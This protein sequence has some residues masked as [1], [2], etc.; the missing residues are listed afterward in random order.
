MGRLRDVFM[1]QH[2]VGTEFGADAAVDADE[3]LLRFVIP[4]HGAEGTG[5]FA[6]AT[7]NA[8]ICVEDDT[9]SISWS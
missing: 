9:A 2:I 5:F 4:E 8:Q 6:L 7:A 1:S 3:R